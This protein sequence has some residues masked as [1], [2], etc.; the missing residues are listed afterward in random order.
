MYDSWTGCYY[1]RYNF[2][3]SMVN[4]FINTKISYCLNDSNYREY[5]GMYIPLKNAGKHC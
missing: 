4:N 5:I 2:N 1:K 3:V